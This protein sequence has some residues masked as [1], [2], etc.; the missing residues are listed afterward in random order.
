MT[1]EGENELWYIILSIDFEIG[2]KLLVTINVPSTWVRILP[3]CRRAWRS[4]LL[5]MLPSPIDTFRKSWEPLQLGGRLTALAA[6]VIACISIVGLDLT[7]S[8]PAQVEK[9]W[10]ALLVASNYRMPL[11]NG[12]HQCPCEKIF[13][14]RIWTRTALGM[15]RMGQAIKRKSQGFADAPLRSRV[16]DGER[17]DICPRW[18]N[19]KHE[20]KTTGLGKRT[21]PLTHHSGVLVSD[22][23]AVGTRERAE[24]RRTP[25][26][27]QAP[28]TR[29]QEPVHHTRTQV[30]LVICSEEETAKNKEKPSTGSDR[31]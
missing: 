20:K 7:F 30:S 9:Q 25:T 24:I 3:G 1:A 18:F 11:A 5:L 21:R 31:R 14:V 12:D 8:E 23:D 4:P 13:C 2:L 29:N 15:A 17:K 16:L 26:T 19:H 6:N 27:H 28:G 10:E 22:D